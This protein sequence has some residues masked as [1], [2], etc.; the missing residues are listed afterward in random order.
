[1]LSLHRY[2]RWCAGTFYTVVVSQHLICTV[3]FTDPESIS[4]AIDVMA[5]TLYEAEV[6]AVAEFRRVGYSRST[7]DPVPGSG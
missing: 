3:S 7:S 5:A 4:S 6:L 2:R 1:V